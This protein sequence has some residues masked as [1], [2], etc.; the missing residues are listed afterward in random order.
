[1]R[2]ALALDFRVARHHLPYA[3]V[4]LFGLVVGAVAGSLIPL[5]LFSA[6]WI[7]AIS[8]ADHRALA[9]EG[10][11]GTLQSILGVSRADAVRARSI[12]PFAVAAACLVGGSV[13]GVIWSLLGWDMVSLWG[14]AAIVSAVL[15]VGAVASTLTY[16]APPVVQQIGVLVMVVAMAGVGFI[17]MFTANGSTST[18]ALVDALYG[19]PVPVVAVLA[20]GAVLAAVIGCHLS[21]RTH[22]R[23]DL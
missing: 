12:A 22:S 10:P 18:Q 17:P 23:R 16:I 13:V 4:A 15:L 20:V 7:G 21:L 14:L 19:G 3:G 9:V 1:M 2:R 5:W 11:V 6:M 8:M